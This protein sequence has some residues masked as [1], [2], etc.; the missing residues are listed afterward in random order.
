MDDHK[1][2][3]SGGEVQQELMMSS[4]DDFTDHSQ[5][6]VAAL[7]RRKRPATLRA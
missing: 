2:S 5:D 6:E 4:V 7:G 3:M 1:G